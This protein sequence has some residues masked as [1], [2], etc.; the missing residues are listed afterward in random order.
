M[1]IAVVSRCLPLLHEYAQ[2]DELLDVLIDAGE[3]AW[4][5]GAHEVHRPVSASSYCLSL[6][7]LAIQSFVSAR[8]LFRR[9]PWVE[10]PVRAFNVLNR[11]ASCVPIYQP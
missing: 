9:N 6:L 7:Q 2:R 5:R 3:S 11:L 8:T 10:D 4:A 1:L